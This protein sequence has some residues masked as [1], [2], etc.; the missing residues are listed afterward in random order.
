MTNEEIIQ[1]GILIRDETEPAQNTSERVG[2]GIE[3]IGRNLADKDTAIA[4]E[5]A[6][7]GYY[8]CTV[9]SNQLA[10]TA[11]GFTL[12]AHGGNIRIKMSA[13]ASG[14]CTLNINGTGAKTLL[15][16]GATVSS[17]NT[18]EQNEII[19]VFYDPSGNG[20]YLASN[21]QGGG[22][23]AE[24]IKYDNSQSGLSAENMQVALDEI[25]LS[26]GDKAVN[27]VLD[28]SAQSIVQN[29][30]AA[31]GTPNTA[32]GSHF[33]SNLDGYEYV[34][35]TASSKDTY[36]TWATD[37]QGYVWTPLSSNRY[38]VPAN[39]TK[40]IPIPSGANYLIVGITTRSDDY[41]PSAVSLMGSVKPLKEMVELMADQIDV[42]SLC[43]GVGYPYQATQLWTIDDVGTNKRTHWVLPITPEM[44]KIKIDAYSTH[45]AAYAFVTAYSVPTNNTP[46]NFC[47][48]F[49]SVLIIGQNGTTGW[50]NIPSDCNYIIFIKRSSD[51]FSPKTITIIKDAQSNYEYLDEVKPSAFMQGGIKSADGSDSGD[52]APTRI[53][54]EYLPVKKGNIIHLNYN[55]QRIRI[56]PYDI[57]KVLLTGAYVNWYFEKSYTCEADG[58]VRFGLA[59]C[60]ET[61]ISP[62]TMRSVIK[63]RVNNDIVQL[64]ANLIDSIANLKRPPRIGYTTQG[65][66]LSLLHFSDIHIDR[67]FELRRI[68]QIGNQYRE[69]IDD[70]LSTGDIQDRGWESG[71]ADYVSTDGVQYILQA[72]GNHDAYASNKWTFTTAINVYNRFI[73]PFVSNWGVVQPSGAATN[74]YNYWYKDY[75]SQK[76][77]LIALDCIFWDAT[78]KTWLEGILANTPS[79]YSI[80]CAS[81]YRPRMNDILCNMD[82]LIYQ[83]SSVNEHTS[84]EAV[85]A[86]QTYINNGGNFIC[87]LCGHE[88]MDYIGLTSVTNTSQLIVGIA[89]ASANEARTRYGVIARLEGEKSQ[90]LF[91]IIGFDTY[92]KFIRILRVGA[93][94]DTFMRSKKSLCI[95]YE[96]HDIIAQS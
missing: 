77:R 75:T 45:R 52:G 5:A 31:D 25:A 24:K 53:R 84:D 65:E 1:R 12:P 26:I 48:G 7:N 16:N 27:N 64:N 3:G 36:Y 74:G 85:N 43:L 54:S 46:C 83:P 47:D 15:Y 71:I 58:Y 18:W 32:G 88:H 80:V 96:T 22:G 55:N 78:Q 11:P 68:I 50:M 35:I 89:C 33:V 79:E 91:N 95:N 90:D 86:I 30:V 20:Q 82:D 14:A 93:D 73:A 39:T 28:L 81:H 94:S 76:I 57:N 60:D 92:N 17:A 42:N 87:W 49:P 70:I 34:R 67:P 44:K 51:D 69:Y 4:A 8:Q 63:M 9:N 19:S 38:Q 61:N 2:S 62:S 41:T 13:P 23:K 59:E 72:V 66:V 29:W 10:V 6:R 37:V 40:D 21:S 56:I